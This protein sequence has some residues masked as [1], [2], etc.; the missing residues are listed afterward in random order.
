M[1]HETLLTVTL[2]LVVVAVLMQASAMMVIGLTVRKIPGEIQGIRADLKQRLDPLAESVTEILTNSRE[3]AQAIASNMAEVTRI[4]RD[5]TGQ[6]DLLIAELVDRSRLQ[7]IRVD[8][9]VSDIVDKV[10]RTSEKVHEAVLSPLQEVSAVI[11]GV[12]T[13]LEFFFSRRRGPRASEATQDE[14]LFI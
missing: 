4:V 6:V 14:Q 5:R 13:G 12:Q 3:P 1:A 10:G 11:K 2:L 8:Q 7:I 9:L